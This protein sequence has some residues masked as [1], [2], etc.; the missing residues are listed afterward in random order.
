MKITV[1]QE[2]LNKGL[3]ITSHITG[4][5]TTLPILNYILFSA[6]GGVLYLKSTDLE[7]GIIAKVRCKID[8][9]GDCAV[10]ARLIS[11]YVNLLQRN[12]IEI[13]LENNKLNISC[14]DQKGSINTTPTDEYPVI[15]I[16]EEK[17]VYTSTSK[18]FKQGINSVSFCV[19]LDSSRAELKGV[20]FLLEKDKVMA[21]GTDSYRLAEKGVRIDTKLEKP[22]KF[23]LPL[24]TV[25]ELART[26][27]DDETPVHIIVDENQTAFRYGDV[28]LVSRVIEGEY[29]D[30][31]QIVPTSYKTKAVVKKEELIRALKAAGLFTTQ[32]NASIVFEIKKEGEV[33]VYSG[34]GALGEDKTVIKAGVEGGGEKIVFNYKYVLDGLNNIEGDNVVIELTDAYSP[35]IIKPTEESQNYIY[36]IMPIR[37]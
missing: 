32:I 26:L 23:I 29:P 28:E 19:S 1:T 21:V 20:L 24:K 10:D 17:Q 12:K 30:Y 5:N 35:A 6:S 8:R 25:R 37:Q 9:E 3:F 27:P 16:V 36:V 22:N 2:N 14:L 31:K 13:N 18:D 34:A 15:P 4:Q 33:S 11:N 7:I